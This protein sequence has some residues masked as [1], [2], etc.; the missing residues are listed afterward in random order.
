M[1]WTWKKSRRHLD[2]EDAWSAMLVADIMMIMLKAEVIAQ[3][4]EKLRCMFRSPARLIWN[5]E[6]AERVW[7]FPS[8]DCVS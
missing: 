8:E 6:A 1:K 7:S 2:E 5:G 3:L 4:V